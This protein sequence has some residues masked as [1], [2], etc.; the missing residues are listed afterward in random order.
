MGEIPRTGGR[1]EVVSP[2][3]PA[4]DQPAAIAELERR[5]TRGRAGRRAARRH[6]HREVGH[7]GVADRAAAAAHAGDGA[8]QD[9]RGAAGERAAGDA[10]EQRRRVLRLVLRLLPAR[11]VHRA[12]RHLHR[13]GLLDQRGRRA[14]A[15]LRHAQ[16][17]VA[18]RRRRGRVGV[19]HLRPGHAAELPRPVGRADGRR[20]GGARRPAARAGRRAVRPQRPGVQPRHVPGPRRHRRDHPRLRG[21]RDPHRVLRRRDRGA[22]LPAPAHRR[23]RA[24]GRHAADLPGHALRRRAGADGAGGPRHRG[25]A[26]RPAGRAGAPGQ[27]ARGPAAADAHPVRPGDDPPGRVLLGHRELL[28]PHRRPRRRAPRRPR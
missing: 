27:A 18:A 12:D 21:A 1:F 28:A 20:G 22:L 13:E 9:A 11:G 19:V 17:A 16:P 14:A 8:E 15:A 25:R 26:G 23:R 4:G 3:R 7:H 2:H 24:P 5:L 10:A 6:R